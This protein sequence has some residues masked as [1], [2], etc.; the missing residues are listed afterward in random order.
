[1]ELHLGLS[2]WVGEPVGLFE[3]I[4]HKVMLCLLHS[5]RSSAYFICTPVLQVERIPETYY[6]RWQGL[7]T[8]W[9]VV[10]NGVAFLQARQLTG[11]ELPAAC[12]L[13][14]HGCPLQVSSTY[15]HNAG[16]SDMKSGLRHGINGFDVLHARPQ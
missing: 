6:S 15:M 16:A 1:M 3:F 8:L 5:R 7:R 13:S 9:L 10:T 2:E 4:D 12:M 11:N 14:T